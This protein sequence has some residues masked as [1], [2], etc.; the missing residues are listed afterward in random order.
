M[1]QRAQ[2]VLEEIEREEKDQQT[3]FTGTAHTTFD[4]VLKAVD[5]R[6]GHQKAV[7]VL[8]AGA[9]EIECDV[10]RLAVDQLRTAFDRRGLFQGLAH[11]KAEFPLPTKF[12]IFHFDEITAGERL[13][14][15]VGT[16]NITSADLDDDWGNN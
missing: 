9:L 15:W 14:R 5:L 2:T 8:T 1:A 6:G 7:L 11:Y 10:G 16:F 12:E 13:S 4:G 3:Y